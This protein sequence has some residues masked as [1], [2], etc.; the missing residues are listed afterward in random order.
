M[1]FRFTRARTELDYAVETSSDLMAWQ[2]IATNPG[3]VGEE[4]IVTE[5][6]A[7]PAGQRR[8]FRLRITIP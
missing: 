1:T 4:V 6:A 5:D 8:F 3:S 7:Q 2:T